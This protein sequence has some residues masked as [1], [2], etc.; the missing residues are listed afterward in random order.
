MLTV[1]LLLLVLGQAEPALRISG[2]ARRPQ[3]TA[4]LPADVAAK[5][6]ATLTQEQGEA[7][8]RFTLVDNGKEGPPMLGAYERRKDT[9]IFAPRFPLVSEK[10]YRARLMFAGAG[11]LTKDYTLPPRAAGPPAHAVNVYPTGNGLPAN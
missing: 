1:P 11:A 2:D 10:T 6:P 3:V 4:R 8:L 7:L 5:L 9:L